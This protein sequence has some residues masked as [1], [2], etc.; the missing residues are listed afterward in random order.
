MKNTVFWDITPYALVRTDISEELTRA[1][2]RDI[3]E[4]AIL[5]HLLSTTSAT[6]TTN[7]L[8]Q[9]LP[10]SR[11]T[12]VTSRTTESSMAITDSNN[13]QNQMPQI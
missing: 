12:R 1:T 3:P 8:F 9:M 4:D 5:Q 10:H 11:R 6:L 13:L 2:W 7:N